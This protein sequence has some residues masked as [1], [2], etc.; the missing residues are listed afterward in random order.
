MPVVKTKKKKGLGVRARPSRVRSSTNAF[1]DNGARRQLLKSVNTQASQ[2]NRDRAQKDMQEQYE[3]LTTAARQAYN[4]V[5]DIADSANEDSLEWEDVPDGPND[6]IDAAMNG[7][8]GFMASGAGGELRDTLEDAIREDRETQNKK[9]AQDRRKRR[10][11]IAKQVHAF[12]PQMSAIIDAY[13]EWGLQVGDNL[14][15]ALPPLAMPLVE[16]FYDITLV[17]IFSMSCTSLTLLLLTIN[18]HILVQY[19][20]ALHRQVYDLL[21]GEPRGHTLRPW[22]PTVG[23]STRVLELFRVAHL[24]TPTLAIQSW[25]KTLADLHGLPFK[26]YRVQQLSVAYDLYLAI[27]RGLKARVDKAIGR[28]APDWRL[29][30]CC[31]AC[32]Y[33][34]EGEAELVFSILVT[35]DGNDSLKRVLRRGAHEYD[36]EGNPL[37]GKS[38][39]RPDPRAATA[40]EPYF[41]SR[42]KVDRWAKDRFKEF[43]SPDGDLPP[44]GGNTDS[45][46]KSKT[47]C[48]ER[49]KN[50]SEDITKKMHGFVLLV[51]DMVKSG[52]L[53][54]Y[55]LAIA[56]E[57]LDA[58][59]RAIG[60]G[61]DI[62]CGFSTT[63]FNSPLGHRA[64]LQN[65]SCLVGA[66]HGHAHNRLCQLL[67]L[68]RY[69]LGM[70]L[71]DL[72]GCERFFSRSNA[73]AGS[74][75][76]AS[77]FHRLQT[78]STYFAHSDTH[79]TYANLTKFLVD[80]YW[81]A[82]EV[83]DGEAGL[84]MGMAGAGISSVEEF[85]ARLKA[86]L[87]YLRSLTSDTEED[88]QHMEYY[89]R[90]VNLA[91][92]KAKLDLALGETPGATAS[93][94][95]HARENYNMALT[96][97]QASESKMGIQVRWLAE[98]QEWADAAHLVS[99]KRYRLALM[100]LEKLV[101]QRMFEL[102]KMNLSQTGYKLRKH[103]AKALQARSQAIRTALKSYNIAAAAMVPPGRKLT[104]SEVVEYAFLSDFDLLHHPERGI[105]VRAWADPAAR[106]LMDTYFK[107]ERAREEIKRDEGEFLVSREKKIAETD[108]G[109]AWCV[110]RHAGSRFTGTLVLGM[111]LSPRGQNAEPMEGVE[112]PAQT[113]AEA[114]A[115]ELAR[116]M[117]NMGVHDV[118]REI[119]D[120]LGDIAEDAQLAEELHLIYIASE[121]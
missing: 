109:L 45:P 86:E 110:R 2:V 63:I 92:R 66:F 28:D 54:K 33:K 84:K 78:L 72:E 98:S 104:W 73:M 37:P 46:E 1:T 118:E 62:G 32:M 55:P 17:D 22:T 101:V 20:H 74:V 102:T 112:E 11:I 119:D 36:D 9:R 6:D 15:G 100:K 52:E 75:Q 114:T 76:Y 105:E 16:K 51:A 31:P 50:L 111:A 43:M 80:N 5:R 83:L 12:A 25:V 49:W 8:D 120:D 68:A 7:R 115:I 67:F 87:E 42:E 81:Q 65:F 56:D 38:N 19:T 93:M 116:A 48:E 57:L 47:A 71:E 117:E 94:K 3:V 53:S 106:L 82:L 14:E 44:A 39:E 34:L 27:L 64:L 60:F 21:P 97:V 30:N 79:D 103:I 95:L 26:P 77:V 107:I 4:D 99:T 69:V 88:T 91:D 108:P 23:F 13:V 61:Y 24:R 41:L 70:G 35:A 58:F 18:S 59:D 85:P 90:L 89:Q 40:G 29:K 113:D 96:D 10:D 121:D